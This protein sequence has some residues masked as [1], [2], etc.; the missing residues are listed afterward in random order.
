M[1]RTKEQRIKSGTELVGLLSR[2]RFNAAISIFITI[3]ATALVLLPVGILWKV[4]NSAVHQ[5]LVIFAFTLAFAACCSLFT[6]AQKQ[7]VFA[8][9]AAYCAVL[10]IF[11]GNNQS[12]GQIST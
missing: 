6:K 11:L 10:I 9:T 2:E 3:L 7:E 5:I 1:F 12:N 4:E 8:A